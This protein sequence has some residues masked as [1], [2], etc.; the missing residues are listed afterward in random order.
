M[1]TQCIKH[2]KTLASKLGQTML[3]VN[4]ICNLINKV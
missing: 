3:F 4:K 1:R 2:V